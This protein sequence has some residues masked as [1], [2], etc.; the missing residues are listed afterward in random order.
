MVINAILEI[1][2]L[3]VFKKNST[4]KADK[5]ERGKEHFFFLKAMSTGREQTV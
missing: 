5:K 1:E 2:D 3:F 4:N